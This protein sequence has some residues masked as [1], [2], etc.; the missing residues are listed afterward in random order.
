MALGEKIR[1]LRAAKGLSSGQ[2]AKL[3]DVSRAYLWQLEIGGK[4]HPTIQILDKLAKA[5][6]VGVS[7]FIE[8]AGGTVHVTGSMPPGLAD[9]VRQRGRDLGVTKPDVE[10]MQ[11]IH[12]RGSTPDAA[13]DWELLF[14]F[15][16][17]W[18]RK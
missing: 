10:V 2:L 5:L 17:K 15:L 13:E 6:G 18:A 3:A 1:K 9:F 7:E 11:N 16:K 14:L 4:E 12:F 8:E